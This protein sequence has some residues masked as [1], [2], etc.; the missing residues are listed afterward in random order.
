MEFNKAVSNPML[1]GCIELMKAEDT[2]EHRN[3]FAA[4]LAK[5]SLQA[6]AVIVPEPV[7]DAEG[8]LTIA[9]G[10]RVQF[11]MLATPD[12]KKFFMGFTDAVEYRK[13]VERNKELPTFALKFEDYANMLLRRDPQGNQSPAYGFVINP[14]GANVIVPKEMVAGMIAA[15]V[16]QARQMAAKKQGMPMPIQRASA[17]ETPEQPE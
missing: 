12:G 7:A 17:G 3:M 9:P 15:R 4:E 13:W 8:N 10:G 16:A 11:P 2:P 5:A 1:V 14:M 6:P